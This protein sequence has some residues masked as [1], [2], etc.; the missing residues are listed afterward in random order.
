MQWNH[1]KYSVNL[2]KVIIKETEFKV[3]D[4]SRQIMQGISL[5]NSLDFILS[6][7]GTSRMVFST[8]IIKY[9][10]LCHQ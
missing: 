5:I 3:V 4:I 1:K 10:L 6:E 2:K 8:E 7:N 9:D